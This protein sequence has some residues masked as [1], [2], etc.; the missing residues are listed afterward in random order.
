MHHY[1]LDTDQETVLYAH[2][3]LGKVYR[4]LI[5][6]ASTTLTDMDLSED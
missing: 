5:H 2:H 3:I 4:P 6:P 1:I